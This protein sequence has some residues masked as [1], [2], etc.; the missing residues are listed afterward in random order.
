MVQAAIEFF[1]QHNV[2]IIQ[3]GFAIIFILAVSVILKSF[4]E[5][6][7]NRVTVAKKT[8]EPKI[9]KVKETKA[10]V[11]DAGSHESSPLDDLD[12]LEELMGPEPGAAAAAGIA[13]NQKVEAPLSP[14]PSTEA[15]PPVTPV[16]PAA[17]DAPMGNGSGASVPLSADLQN[18]LNEKEKII[19]DLK[20][21]ISKLRESAKN[22]SGGDTKALQDKINE[23][24]NKLSEYEIIEDDIA[25]LSFYK[26]ENAKL[27]NE[28]EK[29][30]GGAATIES[31][32]SATPAPIVAPAEPTILDEFEKTVQQKESL[33]GIA[34]EAHTEKVSIPS[35][36]NLMAEFESLTQKQEAAEKTIPPAQESTP[37]QP[38]PAAAAATPSP[39][40]ATTTSPDIASDI[41]PA[42]LVTEVEKMSE[43][44][45]PV[46]PSDNK[47]DTQKLIEEFEN[48]VNK[49]SS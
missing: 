33:E 15:T 6:P 21:E 38:A 14:S 42:K 8:Q 47:D 17:Q 37:V 40:A 24:T 11:A 2:L 28:L 10:N 41:D 13:A 23:L 1:I 5:E 12:N 7:Q 39:A 44:P 32:P 19:G 35:E 49:A 48:F 9:E 3:I 25:N 18:A 36:E 22:T 20:S 45:P 16:A 34:P 27:K 4:K 26:S 30:K 29:L 46:S 43:A 31:S